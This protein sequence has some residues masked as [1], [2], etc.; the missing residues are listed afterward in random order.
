M[1]EPSDASE[2]GNNTEMRFE[3]EVLLDNPFMI[4]LSFE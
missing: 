2:I 3:T 1:A 4:D